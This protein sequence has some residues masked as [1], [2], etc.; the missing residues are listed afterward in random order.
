MYTRTPDQTTQDQIK[1]F[2]QLTAYNTMLKLQRAKKLIEKEHYITHL[3]KKN[4][5]RKIHLNLNK[6][7]R[8]PKRLR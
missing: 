8:S 1:L 2:N 3:S 6:P 4:N 5:K 7:S